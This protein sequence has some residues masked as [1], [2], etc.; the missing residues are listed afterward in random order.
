MEKEKKKPI[1]VSDLKKALRIFSYIKPFRWLFSLGFFFLILTA[2]ASLAFPKLIAQL[3]ASTPETL[4]ANITILVILLVSQAIAGFFRIVIFV[5]VTEKSL[6]HIRQDVYNRL[7][8]LPM[9]FFS[10]KRVGELNSRIAS[11]TSQIQETLT[12]TLAEFFRQISMVIG[13]IAIEI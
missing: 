6:A 5:N 4:S 1:K 10:E 13:G 11:D 8:R 12:S 9:S 2:L 7:I 3:M